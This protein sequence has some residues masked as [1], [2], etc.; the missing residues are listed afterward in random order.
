MIGCGRR[1]WGCK[2]GLLFLKKKKQKDFPNLMRRDRIPPHQNHESFLVLFFKKER[3]Y[4][5]ASATSASDG[6]APDLRL[7]YFNAPS[8]VISN[9]PPPDL[10]SVTWACGLREA[11]RVRAA[12]AR[13]S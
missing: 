7:E 6:N 2:E 13:A 8:T 9:T 3:A 4:L 10:R 11:I 12:R 5:T 1:I